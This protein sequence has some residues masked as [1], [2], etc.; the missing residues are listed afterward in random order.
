MER[1]DHGERPGWVH[2][3]IEARVEEG[4]RVVVVVAARGSTVQVSMY[5]AGVATAAARLEA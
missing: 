1:S 3:V 5:T 4:G 2:D